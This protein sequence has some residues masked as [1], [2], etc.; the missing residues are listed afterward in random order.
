[1]ALQVV[2]WRLGRALAGR[3]GARRPLAGLV[4]AWVLALVA[5]NAWHA[6]AEAAQDVRI[7]QETGV[8]PLFSPLRAK[9]VLYGWGLMERREPPPSVTG[10]A[11]ALDYPQDVLRCAAASPPSILVILVDAWRYDRLDPETTPHLQAWSRGG[12][13]FEHHVSGGNATRFGVFSLFYGLPGSYWNAVLRAR[14][15]P[16]LMEQLAHAGYDMGIFASAK[17]TR[18]EFDATVFESVKGLR[19]STPGDTAS[20]R[21]ARMTDDMVAF[22]RAR[23]PSS[24]PFFGF[25]FYD[26]AHAYDVPQGAEQPFQPSWDQVNYLA[27]RPGFDKTPYVNRYRNALHAIDAQASRIL[28]ALRETGLDATTIVVLTSDHGEEFDD[29]G[30]NYWGHNGNFSPWQVRVPLVL[31]GPG[32]GPATV[33]GMTSHYDVAPTLL[34]QVLGCTNEPASYSIG[35]PLLQAARTRTSVPLFDF[36]E[37]GI[38]Q[39][40]RLTLL[41]PYG[42]FKVETERLD[43]LDERPQDALVASVRND[44]LRFS[45]ARPSRAAR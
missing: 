30:K 9:R 39:D 22:L 11:A 21:D 27:L 23:T 33:T 12:T 8:L 5:V 25:V 28:D 14:R 32:W 42:G 40:G 26:G 6:W 24:P 15:P 35:L 7:T 13:V 1:V 4:T 38:L 18:P 36:D 31:R 29:T 44:M 2:A 20:Q 17:L 43:V 3:P 19:T 34:S 37:M 10:T 45:K 41:T 16:V